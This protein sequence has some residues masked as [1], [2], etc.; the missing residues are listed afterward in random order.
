MEDDPFLA[1]YT[2]DLSPE[3]IT[4]LNDKP[5]LEEE[6]I[7][8]WSEL[9]KLIFKKPKL[10][11]VEDRRVKA[12][13]ETRPFAKLPKVPV[14]V[15]SVKK[16]VLHKQLASNIK[17]VTKFQL[18]LL[19]IITRY[20]DF[21]YTERNFDNAEE[22]R[23][24]YCIHA[25]NHVLKSRD[26]VVEN[27]DKKD[28]DEDELR[29]QG[30][31]RPKVL[32]L[33]P[34]KDSAYRIINMMISLLS[35]KENF[36]VVH[37]NRFVEEFTGGELTLPRKNPKPEDFEKTFVGNIDDAF[38]IGMA[39][40]KS[41]LKLYENFYNSDIIIA[42]PLGLRMIIGA[43]GESSRDYDFLSSVEVL[44]FDQSE[45][46][47]MQ[48]WDH[49]LHIMN[50]F[51]LQPK[52]AH[53]TDLQRVR[54]WSINGLSKHYR[55][56]ILFSS[57]KLPNLMAILK[58]RCASYGGSVSVVNP[59]ITGTISHVV[60]SL[61]QFYHK[62]NSKT[63]TESIKQRF[64][65][66]INKILTQL[67]ASSEKH[68]LIYVPSYFDFVCIRNYL[69]TEDYSFV[70]ISEYT[71]PGKVARAR[72]LFYHGECQILLYS[73]RFHF[74]N[75]TKIRGIENI[76]FYQLPT[77]AGFYSE[78]CNSIIDNDGCTRNITALY[79]HYD[80]CVLTSIVGTQRAKYML[81]SE[82][83]IHMFHSGT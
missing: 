12:L 11:L 39:V 31:T 17:N 73:E 50:H 4:C 62:L 25:I 60:C 2:Y 42:S 26:I 71:K 36:N 57:C 72:D 83:K 59:I 40:T 21:S 37:K 41:S 27:N 38:R 28:G 80:A 24:C 66:F 15:D 75:R 48:N 65:Y 9:G 14:V 13:E 79:S 16:L 49:V 23:Y 76:I 47:L 7:L 64:E 63:P 53:G 29:D 54:N 44:M 19:S 56:T 1:R 69:K 70:Q 35:P 67:Q 68:V 43:E 77:I 81:T 18:E 45:I 33:V 22:L 30:L 61:K 8:E 55:Q 58:N 51:H 6:T 3:L 74:Y 46:F 20:H 5:P 52:E 34:F 78:L 32:I 82:Q 10:T